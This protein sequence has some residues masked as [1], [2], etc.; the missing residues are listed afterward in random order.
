MS[1]QPPG[2]PPPPPPPG[3]P[4]P[5]NSYPPQGYSGPQPPWTA[6]PPPK[7][8]GQRLEV[9]T[10]SVSAAGGH[11]SDCGS[12]D[13]GHAARTERAVRRRR[14]KLL[15]WQAPTTR[16][17][18]NIITEDPS[19]AAWSPISQT[20]APKQTEGLG[21]ARPVCPG[22]GWTPEQRTQ[23]EEVAGAMRKAAD[24]TV[25]LGEADATPR[26]AGTVRAVHRIRPRLR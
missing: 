19:C 6:G 15:V 22:H 26:H 10:R 16:A 23:Y 11:R 8:T 7:E 18:S 2:G 9:G 17:P 3:G 4:P 13:F 12:D 21:R 20:L 14:V 24:Q 1:F 5:G 25:Q